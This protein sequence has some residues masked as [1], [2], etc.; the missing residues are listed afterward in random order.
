LRGRLASA[1][2]MP[3]FL[4]QSVTVIYKFGGEYVFK[5]VMRYRNFIDFIEKKQIAFALRESSVRWRYILFH[6]IS[7]GDLQ[8]IIF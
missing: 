6:H 3:R 5:Y 2:L 7:E 4:L 1:A 8:S